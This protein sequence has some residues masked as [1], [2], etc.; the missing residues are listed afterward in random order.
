M[1]S[2]N[3]FFVAIAILFASFTMVQAGTNESE[4]LVP[5]KDFN[6]SVQIVGFGET[7]EDIMKTSTVNFQ[8]QVQDAGS[9]LNYHWDFGNGFTSN[10]S[11]PT[12]TYNVC[13]T[14]DV[15]LTITD[16]KGDLKSMT[17]EKMVKINGLC[18]A[19]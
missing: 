12:H 18:L 16:K 7:V 8:A 15:T 14:Y 11:N 1:N 10:E 19:K 2:I 4:N 6:Y 13:G 17:I 5:V 9:N 3:N